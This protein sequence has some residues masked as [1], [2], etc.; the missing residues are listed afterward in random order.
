MNLSGKQGITLR[1]STTDSFQFN[2]HVSSS[3]GYGEIVQ[4]SLAEH[5]I[6][7]CHLYPMSIGF[8]SGQGCHLFLLS[9]TKFSQKSMPPRI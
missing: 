9:D 1:N 6:L 4:T 8:W 3:I 2:S 5:L 7:L